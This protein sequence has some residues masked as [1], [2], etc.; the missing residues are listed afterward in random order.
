MGSRECRLREEQLKGQ[1]REERGKIEDGKKK[2]EIFTREFAGTMEVDHVRDQEV[3]NMVAS[4]TWRL[5]R[6]NNYDDKQVLT[7]IK[8]IW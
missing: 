2:G 7:I 6:Q 8:K 1:K 4:L 5:R 3:E